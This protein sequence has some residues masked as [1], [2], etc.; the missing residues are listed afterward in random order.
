MAI[1]T[2]YYK[3]EI[4][5]PDALKPESLTMNGLRDGEPNDLLGYLVVE[6]RGLRRYMKGH[7]AHAIYGTFEKTDDGLVRYI[8]TVYTDWIANGMGVGIGH[9]PDSEFL[10]D[11]NWLKNGR[12]EHL[13]ENWMPI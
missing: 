7:A 5:N 13:D 10:D 9:Y 11:L 4:H 3:I 1:T 2:K 8:A 6:M 12:V